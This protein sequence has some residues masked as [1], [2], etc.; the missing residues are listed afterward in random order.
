MVLPRSKP[1][2]SGKIFS[3]LDRESLPETSSPRAG[4]PRGNLPV[5]LDEN[6]ALSSIKE[7]IA[8]GDQRLDPMLANIT[9]AARRLTGASGAALAMWKE[10]AMVCRARSGD[11]AP[12][13]GAR[14]SAETGISGECLRTSQI[15][16]CADTENDPLVD[17]EVCRRLGLRSI[18]V[19]PIQGWRGTNGIL[20][21]F[22]TQPA[23][24][25]EQ[26]IAFLQQL[27][28]LAERA[29][30]AQPHGASSAAPKPPLETP[31]PSG[32]LPASDRVGDVALAFV[33]TRSRP[34]VLGAIGLLTISLLALV[35]WLGWRGPDEVDGKAHAATPSSVPSA[36]TRLPDNDDVWKANPGGEPL[37]PP[38]GKTPAGIAVKL[39]S[40]V[41]VVPE[42][43]T[44][45]EEIRIDRSPLPGDAASVPPQ[46]PNSQ[47]MSRTAPQSDETAAVE[48]PSISENSPN[49]SALN[50]VLSANASLPGLTAP[51][52]RGVSGGQFIHSVPPV[53]PA[54]ARLLRLEGKVVLSAMIME[55]GT[56]SDAKV[57]E[58]SPVFAQSAIDAVK[59]WRYK[60]YE[61]DGKPVKNEVRI[62][63]DFKLPAATR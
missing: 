5:M 3:A 16:H 23:A 35:I 12:V 32:L 50:G 61:L 46:V 9:D 40:K 20:E 42:T 63:V 53:Y 31:Q 45:V 19:L 52:S 30:A 55:D 17:L 60:P 59:N 37:F 48:P 22:S 33:G 26:H 25:T 7:L 51:V 41:D 18:V 38:T 6:L 8:A 24:F 10:G 21:I 28:A 47:T 44:Q 43:K 57:V 39:A 2:R 11:T 34:F 36:A 54:Q 56:V 1:F 49:Q 15:Q 29:R 62:T 27:A 58:G 14:L 4:S 13:L